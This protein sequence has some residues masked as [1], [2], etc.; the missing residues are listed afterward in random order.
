M[1]ELVVQLQRPDLLG[2][3]SAW[4]YSNPTVMVS[5][6]HVGRKVA[7]LGGVMVAV[8]RLP[9]KAVSGSSMHLPYCI[10]DGRRAASA[11]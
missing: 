4:S 5:T 7:T 6:H 9:W 8:A 3:Q 10:S 2:L 11:T 1:R